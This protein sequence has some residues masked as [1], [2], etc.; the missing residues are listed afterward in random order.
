LRTGIENT[1]P[2]N[3]LDGDLDDFIKASLSARLDGG[4]LAQID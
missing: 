4:P 2:Q 3:V 1:S